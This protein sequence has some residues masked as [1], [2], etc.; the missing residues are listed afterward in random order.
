MRTRSTEMQMG[1]KD[2][3]GL[4]RCKGDVLSRILGLRE[5]RVRVIFSYCHMQAH[6]KCIINI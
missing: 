5:S 2:G 6:N 1:I 3:D 4:D